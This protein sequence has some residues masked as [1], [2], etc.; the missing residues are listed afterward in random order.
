M[1]R[2][3]RTRQERWKAWWGRRSRVGKITLWMLLAFCVC[4]FGEMVGVAKTLDSIV[5]TISAMA[6][7][8]L[9]LILFFRWFAYRFLWRVRNRL[10]LTYVLMGL[11]PVVMFAT[12]TGIAAYLL[13]AQY[14][15]DMGTSQI[16]QALA[17]VRDEAGS[18]A[19]YGTPVVLRA[20]S[21]A[22]GKV[23]AKSD[24]T[25]SVSN[26]GH[27][28]GEDGT[29]LSLMELKG[30]GWVP[31]EGMSAKDNGGPLTSGP[32]PAWVHP[33]FQGIVEENDLLYLVA[34][35]AAPR[36]GK[37]AVVLASRPLT[38]AELDVM[39][40]GLGRIILSQGFSHLTSD[41]ED[42]VGDEGPN[43]HIG[44]HGEAKVRVAK[45][46]HVN[47]VTPNQLTQ[48]EQEFHAISSGPLK[49]AT[50]PYLDPPVVFSAELPVKAWTTGDEVQAM[51]AVF[52][53]PSYLY[54]LLFAS[55]VKVGKIV[56]AI[57]IGIAIFFALVEAFALL[58]ASSLSWTITRSVA[59]LYRGTRA[60]DAGHLEY[61]IPV[62]RKDQLAALATSFNGMAASV[63]ELLVQQREK[64]RLLNELAIAQEVQT[65]LFPRSP[66]FMGSLEVHGTC[67]PARTVGGDY[68]DFI[69]G[70]GPGLGADGKSAGHVTLALGDISGKGISAALLMSALHSADRAFSAAVNEEG[71]PVS[72]ALLLK[73]LNA[74]LYRSTQS[75]RYATLFL[76]TY[77]PAT[78]RLTYSNGGHLPPL[79]ISKD[80]SVQRL[81][82]GG[83]VVGLLDGLEYEEATVQLEPGD[84]LVAYTDGLTEPEKQGEDF[85]EQRLMEFVRA[86]RE[87]PLTVLASNTLQVV[88]AWIG[89]QEQPDDMTV[90]L[91]RQG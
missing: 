69:F 84:L 49:G 11:A 2:D 27:S 4:M 31:L 79:V 14:A 47:V 70:Y 26:T 7:M 71:A 86:H 23:T 76:A 88:K 90:V 16:N 38:R 17:Q 13:A 20:P 24:S 44:K 61:R 82:V 53:R 43:V 8:P 75:A 59:D 35:V 46:V 21:A 77:D 63:S 10:I 28:G 62:R 80:G 33:G 6:M 41:A 51:I 74:H 34:E 65:T 73:L 87:E 25:L 1:G 54:A 32:P 81:E 40:K 37:T 30:N 9:L 18:A 36:A 83:A 67:L 15:V 52:S 50:H 57:V 48:D 19:I 3:I 89:E 78:R 55:S 66:A 68:F 64:E 60:I 39:A 72:P 58:M 42:E 91:A 56:W 45:N 85:G 5:I 22:N 29:P 12:L